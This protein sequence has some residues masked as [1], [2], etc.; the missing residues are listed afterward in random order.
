MPTPESSRTF[1]LVAL[2]HVVVEKVDQPLG[3]RRALLEFD[4]R[5]DIFRVLTEDHDV[6]LLRVLH[7]AGNTLVILH[8]PHAG[9]E[10]EDLP[11]GHVERTDAAAYRSRQRSL[12]RYAQIARRAHR[13]VRQPGGKLRKCLLAGEDLK[14]LHR[15]AAAIGLFHRGIENPLG[16]APDIPPGSVAFNERDDGMVRNLVFAIGILNRLAPIGQGKTV[17]AFLHGCV[18][19]RR[20]VNGRQ[21]E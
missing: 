13:V 12:D 21:N 4:A 14:P 11:Q 17:I 16:C 20:R 3:I 5:V 9:I 7:R 2:E 15:P 19:L 10:I 6:E 8:R 18:S 1:F